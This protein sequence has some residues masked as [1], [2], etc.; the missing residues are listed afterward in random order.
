MQV[1]PE[2]VAPEPVAP[3]PVVPAPVEPELVTKQPKE[4][5][6]MDCPVCNKQ[7]TAKTFKY[8]HQKIC[9]RIETIEESKPMVKETEPIKQVEE[10]QQVRSQPKRITRED[11]LQARKLESEF[12][13]NKKLDSVKKIMSHAF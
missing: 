3:A 10:P 4:I 6:M 1:E 11:Y 7:M 8:S 9:P 2:P 12:L 13:R 5:K